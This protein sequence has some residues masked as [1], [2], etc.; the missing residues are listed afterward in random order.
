MPV[1][2]AVQNDFIQVSSATQAGAAVASQS[3]QVCHSVIALS[4]EMHIGHSMC[5]YCDMLVERY[6]VPAHQPVFMCACNA[7][8]LY[9]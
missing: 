1:F 6:D 2:D 7:F 9:L 5:I 8:E 4:F 3:L